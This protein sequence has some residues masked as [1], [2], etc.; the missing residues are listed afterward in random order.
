VRGIVRSDARLPRVGPGIAATAACLL[1]ISASPSAHRLDEYLQAARVSLAHT[2]VELEIDLT[3]GASVADGIIALIDRDGDTRISPPE[4]ERYGR[5]V[6]ADMVLELDGRSV[7]LTLDRVEAPS[8]EEMRHGLGAIQVRASG[9]VEPRMSRRREL[10]F[11]NNHHPAFSV[12]LVNALIPSDRGISVVAQTRD[13]KQR[14]VRIEYS[15]SPQWPKYV[16]WPV[17]G[18]AAMFFV[19]RHRFRSVDH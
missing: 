16:Y 5:D 11:R 19:Y 18:A 12:Y 8:L 1:A 15:I 6:L 13:A 10:H 17:L 4:A 3:P 7:T 14:D 2:R 9:D